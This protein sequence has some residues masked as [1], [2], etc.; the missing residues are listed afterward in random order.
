MKA[1]LFDQNINHDLQNQFS[2]LFLRNR[3]SNFSE[4]NFIRI[5]V[6]TV[7]TVYV[8]CNLNKENRKERNILKFFFDNTKRE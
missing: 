1:Y 3:M 6:Y 5:N 4:F 2:N 8:W 7:N